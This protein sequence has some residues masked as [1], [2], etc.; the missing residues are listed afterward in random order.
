MFAESF[1]HLTEIEGGLANDPR[2]RGG[3]TYI[4]L[5]SRTYPEWA[6]EIASG[7]MTIKQVKEIYRTDYWNSIHGIEW[8]E[9]RMPELAWL[10]FISKVHGA[11]DEHLV[12][13]IQG[14][15][16]DQVRRNAPLAV[17]G[18]FGPKT[19]GVLQTMLLDQRAALMSHIYGNVVELAKRR[20]KSVGYSYEAI[21]R[22]VVREHEIAKLLKQGESSSTYAP[23]Y[24]YSSYTMGTYEVLIREF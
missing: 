15:I 3:V 14:W 10:L 5:S 4:G 8:L 24:A 11:G 20:G 19:L 9:V 6:E 7:S 1:N 13:L 17:D 16:N 22:R 23:V 18:I 2:D 12:E 21:E